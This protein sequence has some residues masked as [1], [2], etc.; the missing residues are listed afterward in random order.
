MGQLAEAFVKFLARVH[1]ASNNPKAQHAVSNAATSLMDLYVRYAPT[2]PE[3]AHDAS[4]V[5]LI[6]NVQDM[7]TFASYLLTKG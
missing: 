6:E 7:E 5:K 4:T 3:D 2:E 1:D